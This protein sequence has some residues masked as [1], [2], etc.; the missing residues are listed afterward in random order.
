MESINYD[1]PCNKN[2]DCRSNVCEL[3]YENDKPKGRYCLTNTDKQYTISCRSNKDCISGECIDIYDDNNKYVNSKCLKAPKIDKDTAYNTLFGS[4]R[5]NQYGLVNGKTIQLKVGKRG[6]ITEIII[7]VFSIIGNLFNILIFNTDVCNTN[8]KIAKKKCKD[9]NIKLGQFNSCGKKRKNECN[10]F[11]EQENHG[12]IYGSFFSV[13]RPILRAILGDKKG[14]I[15]DRLNRRY[16][17]KSSGK[18]DKRHGAFSFDL[19]YVRTL[20]TILF[21]PIG[22]FMAKGLKGM[23]QVLIC[24]VLT[25]M[26]YVPGL[27]YGLIVINGS[28]I[29]IDSRNY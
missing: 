17:N 22:V 7:K 21:P 1:K 10:M 6:P 20:I 9:E 23:L 13:V 25:M 18:C 4:D 15:S 19:W 26:F 5:D 12:L 14:L 11:T 28:D 3:I 16:Y 8:R 29:D 2:S 27:I 24:C